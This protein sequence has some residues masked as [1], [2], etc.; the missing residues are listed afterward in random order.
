MKYK[1][2]QI[3]LFILLPFTNKNWWWSYDLSKCIS[4][5]NMYN[6]KNVHRSRNILHNKIDENSFVIHIKALSTSSF[7]GKKK[8]RTDSITRLAL[9]LCKSFVLSKLLICT[10]K[11]KQKQHNKSYGCTINMNMIESYDNFEHDYFFM[12]LL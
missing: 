9:H 7:G 2:I 11:K 4:I 8:K 12:T 1:C 3:I 10:L 5:M 6:N